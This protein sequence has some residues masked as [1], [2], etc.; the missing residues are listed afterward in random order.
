[1][2]SCGNSLQPAVR[3]V[4]CHTE[5]PGNRCEKCGGPDSIS[6]YTTGCMYIFLDI[7]VSLQQAA[8]VKP[9]ATQV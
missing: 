7:F 1:V 6:L 3:S 2:C 5:C 9:P 4:A 8:A